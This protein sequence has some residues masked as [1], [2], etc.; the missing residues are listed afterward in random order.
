MTS[1]TRW[2]ASPACFTTL[3][4]TRLAR[5]TG[6]CFRLRLP[7]ERLRPD[8]FFDAFFVEEPRRDDFR[9]VLRPLDLRADD[10]FAADFFRLLDFRPPR[11][12]PERALPRDDRFFVA[13]ALHSKLKVGCPQ[14]SARIARALHP[15]AARVDHHL[16]QDR[17]THTN[18]AHQ[19]VSCEGAR[20]RNGASAAPAVTAHGPI[21][22]Q[23][24]VSP[25]A[26]SHRLSGGSDARSHASR[27]RR[28]GSSMG[29]SVSRNVPQ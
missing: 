8:D 26:S 18:I 29:S 11:R 25:W 6:D 14:M 12:P 1:G 22:D 9:P 21:P 15:S 19:R 5:A 20:R 24:R 2:T 17:H 16:T 3:E 28:G 7:A 27:V 23:T 4:A 10:F 13:M